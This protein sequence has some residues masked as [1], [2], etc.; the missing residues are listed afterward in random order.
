MAWASGHHFRVVIAGPEMPNFKSYWKTFAHLNRVIRL[1]VI[2]DS[3]K[4]DYFAGI[5]V[6]DIFGA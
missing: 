4:R 3:Q 2:D 5:D 1:G 6:F